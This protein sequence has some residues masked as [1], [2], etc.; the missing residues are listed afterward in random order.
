[1]PIPKRAFGS[2]GS[3][4]PAGSGRGRSGRV[5]HRARG[6]S[7]NTGGI[8]LI[9]DPMRRLQDGP[10]GATS[11]IRRLRAMLNA[12]PPNRS[13]AFTT[14]SRNCG[15]PS[16]LSNE[17]VRSSKQHHGDD[18]ERDDGCHA[19]DNADE[20]LSRGRQRERNG[21]ELKRQ[22]QADQPRQIE[23]Q[24]LR[25]EQPERALQRSGNVLPREPEEIPFPQREQQRQHDAH[26]ADRHMRSMHRRVSQKILRSPRGKS[27]S[28]NPSYP[29]LP[30]PATA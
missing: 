13:T 14:S 2:Q 22:I 7:P 29:P 30:R 3:L 6:Y 25:D 20:A 4:T 21:D 23:A 11:K 26:A 15:F 27:V 28:A 24:S 10:A 16:R 17:K 12:Y 5:R 8:P 18:A 1:M 9:R 19:V